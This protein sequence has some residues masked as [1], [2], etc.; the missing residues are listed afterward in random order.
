MP[1]LTVSNDQTI[2]V[3][4]SVVLNVSGAS[5]YFWSNGL[6]TTQINVFPTITTT[7]T[8]TGFDANSCQN[9]AS[10]TIMVDACTNISKNTTNVNF[11]VYPIPANDNITI[12]LSEINNADQSVDIIIYSLEGKV[13]LANTQSLFDNTTKIDVSSIESGVYLLQVKSSSFTLNKNIIISK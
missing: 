12:E 9:T 6:N 7:Y 10:A 2:C 4:N 1:S 13:V 3:G 8:V 5:S 11:K